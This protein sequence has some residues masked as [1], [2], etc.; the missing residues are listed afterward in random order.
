MKCKICQFEQGHSQQCPHYQ[1]KSFQQ[2]QEDIKAGVDVSGDWKDQLQTEFMEFWDE[3]KPKVGLGDYSDEIT[4]F[5]FEKME[6]QKAE[7]ISLIMGM[8][9][10]DKGRESDE[11]DQGMET[12][13]AKIINKIRQWNK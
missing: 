4:R 12:M 3:Y 5:W 2:Y 1:D 13:R 9:T 8:E 6:T 10:K 7:I 11:F